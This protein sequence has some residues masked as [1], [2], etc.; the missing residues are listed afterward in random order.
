MSKDKKKCVIFN[1]IPHKT[2]KILNSNRHF[3]K[4]Y[5]CYEEELIQMY[6]TTMNLVKEKYAKLSLLFG[7]YSIFIVFS[8]LFM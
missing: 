3:E 2:P 7:S 5:E 4:W 1:Y 8:F 6:Y